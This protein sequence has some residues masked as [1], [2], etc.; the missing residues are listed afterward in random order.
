MRLVSIA[1]DIILYAYSRR[2]FETAVFIIII[3][4]NKSII[5]ILNEVRCSKE[6]LICYRILNL[7]ALKSE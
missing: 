2:V 5:V 3:Q 1:F 7:S 6:L 4:R